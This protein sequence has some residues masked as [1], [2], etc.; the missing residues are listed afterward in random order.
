[1]TAATQAIK[2]LMWQCQVEVCSRSVN[3]KRQTFINVLDQQKDVVGHL[4]AMKSE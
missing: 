4:R 2:R 3:V 1:M